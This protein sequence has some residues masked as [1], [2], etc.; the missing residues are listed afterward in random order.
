M[1]A[2]RHEFMFDVSL[3]VLA[4]EISQLNNNNNKTDYIK[5][6]HTF[7]HNINIALLVDGMYPGAIYS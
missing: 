5:T 4:D 6:L 2:P 1:Q 7:R 3:P